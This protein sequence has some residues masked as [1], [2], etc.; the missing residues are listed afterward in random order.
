MRSHPTTVRSPLA[1]ALVAA[2]ASA[3]ATARPPAPAPAAPPAPPVVVTSPQPV[4]AE[5]LAGAGNAALRASVV[6]VRVTGQDWNWRTPWEKQAPWTRT[7]TGLVVPGKRIL[8]TSTAFGNPL[9]VEAQKLGSEARSVARVELVDHEGPLALIAVDDPAFWEGLEPLPLETR[10][11]AEGTVLILRWQRTGL[12]DAYPGTLR[13]VRSGRH[14]LSQTS[15]LTVDVASSAEGLGESEVVVSKGKVAGLVTGRSG[16]AYSA[17]AA[18][19]LGQFLEEAKSNEW[20]SFARA[21][22]AW[23]DLT[24]PALRESL[25]LS[26]GETGIRLTRVLPH[27]SA[28]GVLKPG[29]VLLELGGA[30]LDPT[31]YYEHPLYGRMLFP[32]LFTDGRHPG[33]AM[34]VKVL[35]EG[36]RLDLTLTL[37]AM[38]PEQDRVPPY[39]FGRGPDYLI[40]GGL[41]FEELTR[42]Y[43]ASWGDWTRRAPPRLL[44]AIDRDPQEETATGTRRLVLLSS[45]LPDTANLGYQELRDLIVERVNGRPVASL[46]DLRQAFA[47]PISGF[48]V[49]EFLAGQSAV[50]IVLDAVG[51]RG[52]AAAAAAG[53]RRRAARLRAARAGAKPV[54]MKL[55]ERLAR[56]G[57]ETAFEVLV[58]ARALEAKGRSVIHLEIGEPDFDTPA[59]VVEAGI[60]ALKAGATHYGPA[61]GLPELRQAVAEDSTARR[62]VKAT[63]EMVVV[64]PGGKPIMFYLILALVDPGDEVLYPNPGFPI[65]ESMIRYIGGVP[66]PVRL[67]AEKGH[68]LDVE[69]LIGKITPRT[70]L[71]VLN[72]PHNPTG[73]IIPEAGLRAIADAAVR[74][75]IPVLSDEIYSQILYDGKHVSIAAMPGMESLAIVLDGFSKTYAMTGWRLGYG[76]MPAPLAQVVAKLQTNAV[77]CTAS[78]TQLAGVQALK[79]DHAPIDAMVAEFRKR[80]DAIVDGLRQV[81]GIKCAR[82]QGAFYVFPDITAT[83]YSAK[84]LADRLL[85]EAG[86]ACLS[87]TAF[88]EWGEGHLRFSYA[89]SLENIQ[90]ALR[91]IKTCL[92]K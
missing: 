92:A 59:H 55:S 81:P 31:G 38:R 17:I 33:D 18:P 46:Q 14:G 83:G 37:K 1:L 74:A 61:A 76:I 78:F 15:V 22:L 13:Q 34:P 12:L 2:F 10:A 88:G 85:D 7:V 64:T 49:V 45:V 60:A 75:G 40:V 79:G 90:E 89:S 25:G 4:Q 53:L 87:G 48:H 63:P 65:Y 68:Q 19:V 56:L 6:S 71:I 23:Q 36:K 62:G 73:G 54:S 84:A 16:D 58:R 91:R 24:N 77:S 52:L 82:P 80:R 47:T 72:Y 44:V 3:C 26:P 20:R 8:A 66:V 41:V 42:P 51:S 9:L 32:L 11:S 70:R 69:Q 57:T 86:V 39:V 50:K 43:L 27:G 29:D 21:G 28:G 30:K 5:A 67:L 35:R